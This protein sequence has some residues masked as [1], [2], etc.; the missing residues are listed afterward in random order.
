MPEHVTLQ[1]AALSSADYDANDPARPDVGILV[2]TFNNG[3]SYTHA[4]VPRSIWDRLKN[5]SSPG[6]TYLDDIKG[7]F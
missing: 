5:S 1:S 4:N 6:R 7:A 3:R 2:V